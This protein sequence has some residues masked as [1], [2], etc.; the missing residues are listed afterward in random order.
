MPMDK[1]QSSSRP[2][3]LMVTAHLPAS[4]SRQA[5]QKT[6][7]RNLTWL[8]ERYVVDLVAA[9]SSEDLHEPRDE[10]TELCRTVQV[11]PLTRWRRLAGI[12]TGP[13]LP[14]SVGARFMPGLRQLI[15]TTLAG[16]S[17]HRLHLEWT[18]MAVHLPPNRLPEQTLNIHDVLT[19]WAERRSCGSSG[20]IWKWEVARTRRWERAAYKRFDRV[21]APSAK[22]SQ[23]LMEL[24]PERTARFRH[25]P[26][27]F[28]RFGSPEQR[29]FDGPPRLLFWGAMS[30]SENLHA[31][32]WLKDEVL[33]AVRLRIPGAELVVVGSNP[34][35]TLVSDPAKGITVTGFLPDP[36]AIFDSCLLAVLP[37]FLGAGI[38]V[39]VLECLASGMPTLVTPVGAE[40]VVADQSDGLMIL[41]EDPKPWIAEICRLVGQRSQ[42]QTMGCGALAWA[43]KQQS[44]HRSVIWEAT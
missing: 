5:G 9:C 44:D 23:L 34:P 15:R 24:V 37:L 25:L 41:P 29:R 39:K 16:R 42:L 35:A 2:D 18:Q 38:K 7:Y 10:L 6:A 4:R 1:P 11:Y 22:D 30:R 19:Q 17:Y 36:G 13:Y 12:L 43:D 3:L 28:C 32:Q 26:P 21:Y 20:V 27:P 40:G 31:V 14:L 33:P 8:A